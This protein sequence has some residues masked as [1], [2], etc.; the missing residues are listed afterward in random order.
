MTNRRPWTIPIGAWTVALCLQAVM[1][2][3]AHAVWY[4]GVS[5]PLMSIDDRQ[6]H[7]GAT[8]QTPLGP[9]S[10]TATAA[11]KHETGLKFGGVTGYAFNFGLRVEAEVFF[12]SADIERLLYSNVS[13][14]AAEFMLS[15]ETAVP[16]SGSVDQTGALLN[17]WYDF[18][19][20]V[21]WKPYVGAGVGSVRVDQGGLA[22]DDGALAQAV[23]EALDRVQ[24]LT[25][26]SLPTGF[27][28]LPSSSDTVAVYQMEAGV[29]YEL[30]DNITLQAGYRLQLASEPALEGGNATDLRV[31]FF[32]IGVRYYF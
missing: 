17:V 23:S 14:P 16:V 1:A 6:A 13:V 10:Y 11:A 3:S 8:L 18:E 28:A 5:L 9:L 19:T 25:L 31:Q 20:S 27:A 26:G 7:T 12:A 22:G 29:G 4:A 30:S 32:E 24:G 15:G 21:A 2:G